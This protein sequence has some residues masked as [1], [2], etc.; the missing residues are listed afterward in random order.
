MHE[1]SKEFRFEAAHRLRRLPD[2]HKCANLHGH[3][4]VFR[5]VCQGEPDS[6][7]SFVIDYAEISEAVTP[8]VDKLDHTVIVDENDEQ[9]I[10]HMHHMGNDITKIPGQTSAEVLAK[11]LYEWI[12]ERLD[13]LGRIELDETCKASVTYPVQ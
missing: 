5:V 8:I 6:E 4:Y 13:C 2:G 3:S 10:H 7:R 9:L 1:V 12:G 11:T